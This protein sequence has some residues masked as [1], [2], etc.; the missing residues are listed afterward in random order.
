M[1]EKFWSLNRMF[2][3]LLL[4]LTF[5]PLSAVLHLL[6]YLFKV[7]KIFIKIILLTFFNV[8]WLY[9]FIVSAHKKQKQTTNGLCVTV[10]VTSP[11]CMSVPSPLVHT[12]D[13]SLY[14]CIV[15]VLSK[16]SFEQIIRQTLLEWVIHFSGT[17][18]RCRFSSSRV[19]NSL[20]L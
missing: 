8:T 20:L 1:I 11:A 7:C 3:L 16:C 18:T 19:L 14:I 15:N 10:S 12:D 6:Q 4:N 2:W 17:T 5:A 13:V 9:I